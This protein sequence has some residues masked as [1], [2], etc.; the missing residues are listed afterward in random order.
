MADHSNLPAP[1]ESPWRLLGRALQAVAASLRLDL[2]SLWRRNRSGELRRPGWWPQDLAPLFWPLLLGAVVLVVGVGSV[3]V[4][5]WLQQPSP[6]AATPAAVPPLTAERGTSEGRPDK[7]NRSKDG[8]ANSPANSPAP[9]ETESALTQPSGVNPSP[10]EPDTDKATA[11][12]AESASEPL[13][14]E[15]LQAM[16]AGDDGNL[17]AAAEAPGGDGLLLLRLN[18]R[19]ALLSAKQ[20]SHWADIWLQRSQELGFDQLQLR[21]AAGHTLGYQARVGSGMILLEP[22]QAP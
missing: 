9:S 5:G 10:L 21:D 18:R 15:L 1:Y 7:D 11:A 4:M 22:A 16:T 8:E 13:Q 19:Y 3:S 17:I 12:P 20:Q 2:R 6:D 14:S